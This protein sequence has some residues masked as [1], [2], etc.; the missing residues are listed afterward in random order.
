MKDFSVADV[1]GCYHGRDTSLLTVT[2]MDIKNKIL[3]D[4]Y[5]FNAFVNSEHYARWKDIEVFQLESTDFWSKLPDEG[6]ITLT[7]QMYHSKNSE[8]QRRG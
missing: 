4:K 2:V 7:L 1:V 5:P 3:L 6:N 8:H